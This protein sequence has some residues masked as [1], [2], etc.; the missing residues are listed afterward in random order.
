MAEGG[1]VNYE[2]ENYELENYELENYEFT[3]V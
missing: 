1:I 2:W 3:P